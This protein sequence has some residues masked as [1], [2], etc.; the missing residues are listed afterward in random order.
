MLLK[1]A[2]FRKLPANNTLPV[3][4]IPAVSPLLFQVGI[5]LMEGTQLILEP[6]RYMQDRASFFNMALTLFLLPSWK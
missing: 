2:T 5:F 6:K 1:A 4:L 3:W